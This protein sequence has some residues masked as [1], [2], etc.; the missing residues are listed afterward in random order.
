MP[1]TGLASCGHGK[2]LVTPAVRRTLVL[3]A[4]LGPATCTRSG[5]HAP[6]LN[7]TETSSPCAAICSP[8]GLLAPCVHHLRKLPLEGQMDT[9]AEATLGGSSSPSVTE[10]LEPPIEHGPL[11]VAGFWGSL[12]PGEFSPGRNP[13]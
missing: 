10:M 8:Q 2:D 6:L 3:G 9:Q 7:G 13:K 1:S 11:G 4:R 12:H 5:S